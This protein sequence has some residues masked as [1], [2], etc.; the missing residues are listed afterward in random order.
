MGFCPPCHIPSKWQNMSVYFGHGTMTCPSSVYLCP[1]STQ[2][3]FILS[4]L[5]G[6]LLHRAMGVFTPQSHY[7]GA[8][9]PHG[10]GDSPQQINLDNMASHIRRSWQT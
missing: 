5:W 1:P 8:G 2:H 3:L 4:H 10:G 9:N 7:C 6:S